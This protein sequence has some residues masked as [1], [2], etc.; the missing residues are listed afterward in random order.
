[1][2]RWGW[3]A[4]GLAL[5]CL[6]MALCPKPAERNA[7]GGPPGMLIWVDLELLRL[8]VYENGREIARFPIAA[9]A[10]ETPSPVGVFHVN[11]KFE[12]SL[13]GFGTRFLGLDVPWGDYG[14]HGTNRPASIGSHASHGCIRMTVKDAEKLYRMIPRGTKVV[15]DGGASGPFLSVLRTLKEGDRGADVMQ[16]Q[17]RLIQKGFL[18]GTADGV[19]GPATRRAVIA[20]RKALD[21]PP[22]DSADGLFMRKFGIILFD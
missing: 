17:R 18:A 1:M 2:N 6:I 9:G 22:G 13:S 15:I 4:L 19:F 3:R 11:R 7:S 12:T 5:L 21:L 16:L 20:A 10:R 14:I 8:T